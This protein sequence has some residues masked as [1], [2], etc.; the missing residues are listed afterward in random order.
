M[1]MFKKVFVVAAFIIALV[2][3]PSE[4]FAQNVEMVDAGITPVTTTGGEAL[5]ITAVVDRELPLIN[6]ILDI[7]VYDENGDMVHQAISETN[8]L[9][10]NPQTTHV[11]TWLPTEAGDYTVSFGLFSTDWS[12]LFAW[13]NDEL[14]F[15][16]EDV[17]SGPLPFAPTVTG[18]ELLTPNPTVGES[19][20][21]GFEVVNSGVTQDALVDIEI[22]DVATGEMVSQTAHVTTLDERTPYDA[23]RTL[24]NPGEYRVAV[25]VFSTDWSE[26]YT[27][28]NNVITFIVED[29]EP[30]DITFLPLY[31]ESEII[32]P[33]TADVAV[34]A[35]IKN[36]GGAGTTTILF[37]YTNEAGEE[38]HSEH[39]EN[40]AFGPGENVNLIS[41]WEL[42]TEPTGTFYVDIGIFSSD[43]SELYQWNWHANEFIYIQ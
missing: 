21:F 19:F 31:V 40:V 1:R 7:E 30:S 10:T 3:M 39:F 14:Q 22:Y 32:T 17:T 9:M 33:P 16:V 26:L 24:Y 41:E 13:Y 34:D 38:V 36:I 27:W 29:E 12:E 42:V 25:G 11:S 43:W 5:N 35:R 8:D 37:V 4:V 23:F 28:N 2:V 18:G 20:G 6:Y 15:T